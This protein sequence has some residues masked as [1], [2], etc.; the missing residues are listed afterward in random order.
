MGSCIWRNREP[1]ESCCKR[2]MTLW[3]TL[4]TRVIWLLDL[5]TCRNLSL[6]DLN[7][8]HPL[9]SPPIYFLHVRVAAAD[10]LNQLADGRVTVVSLGNHGS[11]QYTVAVTRHVSSWSGKNRLIRGLTVT[12]TVNFWLSEAVKNQANGHGWWSLAKSVHVRVQC[13]AQSRKIVYKK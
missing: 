3:I 10:R 5:G 4:M 12:V 13:V 8:I 6:Y 11:G 7:N 9:I 2:D 1:I